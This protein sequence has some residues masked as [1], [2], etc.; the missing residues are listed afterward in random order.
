MTGWVLE[1]A[2]GLLEAEFVVTQELYCADRQGHG[3]VCLHRSNG[4]AIRLRT[5]VGVLRTLGVTGFDVAPQLEKI[6]GIRS[7][8]PSLTLENIVLEKKN[9]HKMFGS[10]AWNTSIWASRA[11]G[12]K[13]AHLIEGL[14]L[15]S[16]ATQVLKA[17]IPLVCALHLVNGGDS[18]P[19]MGYIYETMDQVKETIKEEFENKKVSYMPFW[20]ILDGIWNNILRRPIHSASYF[21]NPNLFYYDDFVADAEVAGQ[22]LCCIIRMV[23]DKK[24]QDL[25]LQQLDEYREAK[26]PFGWINAID[27]RSEIPSEKWWSLYGRRVSAAM[28]V[29]YPRGV[30]KSKL[31]LLGIS[32]RLV[33]RI[34]WVSIYSAS[35]SKPCGEAFAEKTI[36]P[37]NLSSLTIGFRYD[38]TTAEKLYLFLSALA[39]SLV[40]TEEEMEEQ[41]AALRN[42][43]RFDE[44]GSTG[45]PCKWC[46]HAC[47]AE[48]VTSGKLKRLDVVFSREDLS[49]F[50]ILSSSFFLFARIRMAANVLVQE[51]Q[52][53]M[54]VRR[55]W[56]KMVDLRWRL[57]IKEDIDAEMP[58][59]FEAEP[60]API[61]GMPFAYW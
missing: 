23:E 53:A 33:L 51:N 7:V 30:L 4:I 57:C 25:I 32:G 5:L 59:L 49:P 13:V 56:E 40:Y 39:E 43:R 31:C 21:L 37:W 16:E 36:F 42:D 12:K 45:S 52:A 15:W 26:G 44:R 55:I 2:E 10:S 28:C 41:S 9:L 58:N 34:E 18:N 8:R 47:E 22:L 48:T 38:F 14:S 11:D 35:V 24:I 50:C 1:T 60:G 61:L 29:V 19:Q 46:V 6:Y 3:I 20:K 27:Q 17:T 54:R